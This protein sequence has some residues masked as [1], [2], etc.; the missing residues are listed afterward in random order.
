ML[1]FY[2]FE[3]GDSNKKKNRRCHLLG[4]VRAEVLHRRLC[5]LLVSCKSHPHLSEPKK[6]KRNGKIEIKIKHEAALAQL[7][8]KAL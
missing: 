1:P 4:S 6:D 7:S 2:Y 3:K 8:V 5:P